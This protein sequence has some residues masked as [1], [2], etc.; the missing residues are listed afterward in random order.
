[1]NSGTRHVY[2]PT[3]A[4]QAEGSFRRAGAADRTDGDEVR[5]AIRRHDG[6]RTCALRRIQIHVESVD[7]ILI[8]RPE[9]LLASKSPILILTSLPPAADMRISTASYRLQSI[10]GSFGATSPAV[11]PSPLTI[12][13]PLR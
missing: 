6:Q 2:Q 5:Q 7:L 10:A 1:M 9:L 13:S 11:E 4:R 3:G 8:R 12:R